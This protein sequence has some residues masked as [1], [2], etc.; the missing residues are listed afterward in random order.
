MELFTGNIGLK[1]VSKCHEE[2][3]LYMHTLNADFKKKKK[4]EAKSTL[5]GP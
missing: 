2:T 5:T 4:K 3:H 1:F